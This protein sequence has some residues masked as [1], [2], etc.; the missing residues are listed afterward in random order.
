MATYLAT[1]TNGVFDMT[2]TKARRIP[3]YQAVDPTVGNPT[4]AR[5]RL[6]LEAQIIALFTEL[7]G[8]YPFSSGGG[9][10]DV[11]RAN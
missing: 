6:A 4:L 5:E 8:R 11:A 7:Y 3:L 2:V 9:V 10:V 1:A